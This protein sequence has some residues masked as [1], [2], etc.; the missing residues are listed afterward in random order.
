MSTRSR[1]HAAVVAATVAFVAV[2]TTAWLCVPT[3]RVAWLVAVGL[4]WVAPGVIAMARAYREYRSRWAMAFLLGG[5]FG[6]ALSSVCL[7]PFWL[8]GVRSGFLLVAVPVAASVLAWL[9]PSLGRGLDVPRYGR[10]D[11]LALALLI[12]IVPLVVA[13]P[14][15]QVGKD[16][17][18]GRAYRA[19]FTA[20]FVWA[21]AVVSEVSKGDGGLPANPFHV[22]MPLHYYW[23]AHLLPSLEYRTLERE[24][25]LDHLLLADAVLSGVMFLAFLYALGKQFARG[26]RRDPDRLRGDRAVHQSRGALRPV[27]LVVAGPAAVA[28]PLPQHR[29]RESLDVRRAADRW[30]A[31]GLAVSA[32]APDRLCAG[33]HVAA[34]DGPAGTAAPRQRRRARRRAARLRTARQHVLRPDGRDHGGAA[35]SSIAI[36]RARAWR[37]GIAQAVV[38]AIPLAAAVWLSRDLEY[39]VAGGQLIDITPNLLATRHPISGPLISMG[40]ILLVMALGT[41]LWARRGWG[42]A[43]VLV[44]GFAMVVCTLFYFFVD[45][46]DHQDV[47]VGWRAGH[48]FFI[49]AGGMV[50]WTWWRLTHSTP[51]GG[52]SPA[53]PRWPSQR[54]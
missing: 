11:L 47:Y 32:A 14:Y 13:R 15:S 8:L 4:L 6:F 23:L 43:R 42:H 36:V 40:P 29:R 38:A 45:V 5:P 12:L 20:D 16:L 51:A 46:R 28:G 31:E 33:L 44:P 49:T 48:L 34:G 41:W 18:E 24:V 50:G 1:A 27:R 9:T 26:A 39:V 35:V 17:P 10:R 37:I 52:T 53:L 54:S 3:W 25:R 22:D 30:L 19:Y 21:M 7:L 2:A